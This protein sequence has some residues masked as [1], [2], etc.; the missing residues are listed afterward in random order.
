[1]LLILKMLLLKNG[2]QNK[3]QDQTH[4]TIRSLEK[5]ET[6][7]GGFEVNIRRKVGADFCTVVTGQKEEG[8]GL[9]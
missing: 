5:G 4:M 7:T 6:N 9:L 3:D 8:G 1:M 2:M